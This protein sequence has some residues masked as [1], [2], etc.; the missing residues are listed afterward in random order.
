MRLPR[1]AVVIIVHHLNNSR[2]QRILWLLEELGLEY[3]VVKHVRD[4]VTHLA[5]P[6]LLTVHPLGKLPVIRDG[7][8]VLAESGAIIAY[9]L[10]RYGNGRLEPAAGTPER[11]RYLY[12]LHYTEGTAM[13]MLLLHVIFGQ[14]EAAKV[15]F[16]IRPVTRGIAG[17]LKQMLVEPHLGRNFDLMEA[18]LGKSEWFAGNEIT[19]AD[20]H[21]SFALE[22]A[23]A[24]SGL[25]R[26]WPRLMGWL[27]RI[28][29]RPAYLRAIER[30]GPY[31]L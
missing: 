8:L 11:V 2:S 14:L 20:V 18:E 5:P 9:V 21:L 28:H 26:R 10:E 22:A 31:Q 16:F 15:P 1:G 23:V 12:W 24:R 19:A 6:D 4:P 17:R 3:E 25:D 29:A 13:P 27:D 7:D 30:G